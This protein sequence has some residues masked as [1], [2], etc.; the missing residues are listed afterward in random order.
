VL[1]SKEAF[2]GAV[3]LKAVGEDGTMEGVRLL[4]AFSSSPTTD[5]ELR[6]SDDTINGVRLTPDVPMQLTVTMDEVG[7]R[8]LSAVVT[9]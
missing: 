6:V 5:D 1:R 2:T 4:S 7:R 3:R 8:S 9:R